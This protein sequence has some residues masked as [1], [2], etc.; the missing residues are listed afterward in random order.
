MKSFREYFLTEN[1][2]LVEDEYHH[3]DFITKTLSD[4]FGVN[5]GDK[6]INRDHDELEKHHDHLRNGN[7]GKP[8]RHYTGG[9]ETPNSRRI[10][11]ALIS[12]SHKPKFGGSDIVHPKN[13]ELSEHVK[14]ID[15]AMRPLHKDHVVYSGVK[16]ENIRGGLIELSRR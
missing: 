12:W 6:K 7:V 1:G 4:A 14:G 3:A 11:N 15:S 10:N 13:K 2:F 8:I 16:T 9:D 5:H